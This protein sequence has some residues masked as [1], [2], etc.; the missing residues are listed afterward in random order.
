MAFFEL[1]AGANAKK[2][3]SPSRIN[4]SRAAIS[5]GPVQL[6]PGECKLRA[7]GNSRRWASRPASSLLF[8]LGADS[9]TRLEARQ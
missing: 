7:A 8:E 2:Q 6:S 5:I 3:R 1:L 4:R 9:K